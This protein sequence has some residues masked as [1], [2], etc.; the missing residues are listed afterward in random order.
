MYQFLYVL[1]LGL[2]KIHYAIQALQKI[3]KI[4]YQLL[5]TFLSLATLIEY[6]L[7]LINEALFLHQITF[8]RNF[9]RY[10]RTVV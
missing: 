5:I 8:W 7:Q 6:F 4:V 9:L 1:F 3:H 10:I 2:A